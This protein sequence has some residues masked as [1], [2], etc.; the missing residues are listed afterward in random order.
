[1]AK[2]Y[3]KPRTSDKRTEDWRKVAQLRLER[4]EHDAEIRETLTTWASI[5]RKEN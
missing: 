2:T 1:M 5:A 3:R 4:A